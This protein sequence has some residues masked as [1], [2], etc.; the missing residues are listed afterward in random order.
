VLES[1]NTYS[2]RMARDVTDYSD[3]FSLKSYL[4]ENVEL[5]RQLLIALCGLQHA[6][7]PSVFAISNLK[8]AHEFDKSYSKVH[9]RT[10]P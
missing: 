7:C 6:P 8:N 1:F 2:E 4:N 10:N 3:D 5:K 9:P